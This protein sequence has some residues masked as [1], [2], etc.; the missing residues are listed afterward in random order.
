MA[1]AREAESRSPSGVITVKSD[2]TASVVVDLGRENAIFINPYTGETARRDCRRLHD[3]FHEIV[4]W[5]RWLGTEGESRA[6]GQAITGACNLAF[7]W[8]AVTGVYL[9]WPHSWKWRGLK[10]SLIL[11]VH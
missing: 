4:D 3:L 2:P 11:T 8:L 1:K 9:W 5:H 7:F 6:T 10:T